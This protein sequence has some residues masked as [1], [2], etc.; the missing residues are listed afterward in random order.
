VLRSVQSLLGLLLLGLLAGCGASTHAADTPGSG[1]TPT[2]TASPNA[3]DAATAT[4][5]VSWATYTNT[6][7]G[8]TIQNPTNWFPL[9]TSPTAGSFD[10]FSYD[11]SKVSGYPLPSG[12]TK[13]EV[14]IYPNPGLF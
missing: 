8:Y 2:A 12:A 3:G 11:S 5:S 13:I 7:Y 10:V 14:L 1:S 6:T 9:D 4:P